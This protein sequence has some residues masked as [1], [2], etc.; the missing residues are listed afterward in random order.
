[1]N[2]A[3]FNKDEAERLLGTRIRTCVALTGVPSGALGQVNGWQEAGR[4]GECDVIVRFEP[5]LTTR[6]LIKSLSKSDFFSL[7][8][9]ED[10]NPH[11]TQ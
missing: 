9:I 6:P 4:A 8:Q 5:I 3:R 2:R 11:A 10:V 1:M 7:L